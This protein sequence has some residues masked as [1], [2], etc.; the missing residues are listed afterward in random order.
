MN[1]G[2][3]EAPTIGKWSNGSGLAEVIAVQIFS[4]RNRYYNVGIIAVQTLDCTGA[5]GS[6]L[7]VGAVTEAPPLPLPRVPLLLEEPERG[8]VPLLVN[9]RQASTISPKWRGLR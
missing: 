7:D 3:K 2:R 4:R 1:S 5:L 8:A 9:L 6:W